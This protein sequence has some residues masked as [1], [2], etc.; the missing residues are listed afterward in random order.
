MDEE[1]CE[2]KLSC[3][4]L[5]TSRK[6]DLAAEFNILLPRRLQCKARPEGNGTTCLIKTSLNE[7]TYL[8]LTT[9]G[10]NAMYA[11]TTAVMIAESIKVTPA[12]NS[13]QI[14]PASEL[15]NMVQIL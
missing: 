8:S 3:T 7:L 12:P 5:K 4:V 13:Y 9:E 10:I 11:A 2:G 15:A 6:G 1:P 14:N